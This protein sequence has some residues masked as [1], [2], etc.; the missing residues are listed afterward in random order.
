MSSVRKCDI[1]GGIF[2]SHNEKFAPFN[3]VVRCTSRRGLGDT[4]DCCPECTV[5]INDF[6]DI[7]K[8]GEPY[9]IYIGNEEP[10]KD[11]TEEE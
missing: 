2:D 7:L 4:V 11:D 8:F 1:C 9:R 10:V 5:K 6:I 3:R